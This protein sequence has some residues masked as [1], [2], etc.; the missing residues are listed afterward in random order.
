[1]SHELA[2]FHG[3]KIRLSSIGSHRRLLCATM[4]SRRT[5]HFM[6]SHVTLSGSH[7]EHPMNSIAVGKPDTDEIIDIT[8][9]L[10]RRTE[11]P[12]PAHDTDPL[13]H[14]ELALRHGADT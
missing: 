10:R 7:C 5:D 12:H 1:M 11:P 9:I 2:W 3:L 4:L 14:E 6:S 8:L 13:S